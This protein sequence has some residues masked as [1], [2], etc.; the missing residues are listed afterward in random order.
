M[1][2]GVLLLALSSACNCS[3]EPLEQALGGPCYTDEA[4]QAIEVKID[5][6]DFKYL[7][8]GICSTGI[9]ARSGADLVC[10]DEIKPRKE[11][12]NS[13]DDDCNGYVDD[14]DFQPGTRLQMAR[15]D[16]ENFCVGDGVCE[17][18]TQICLNGR[19]NC[20]H[21]P[22]YGPE[23]C[24]GDDNDCDGKI[25]EDTAEEPLFAP[26]DRF[27][28]DGDPNTINVGECRAG[29]KQCVGGQVYIR[30]M[31]TPVTE[32]CGNDDDDDCDG[33]VDEAD[34]DPPL[35]DYVLVIDFSG[36]MEVFID[37]VADSLCLWSAQGSLQDSRFAVIAVGYVGFAA[38]RTDTALLTDF[39]D[40]AT[41][42][43]IIQ[44]NNTPEHFGNSEYQIDAIFNTWV[45][46][47]DLLLSW[48][49]ENDKRIFVFTDEAM[50][51]SIAN[52]EQGAIDM[53]VAQCSAND[54]EV[55][56][57]VNDF[58]PS[59]P[60]WVDLTQRCNGFL[61]YLTED[62]QEMIFKLNYWVGS[63]CGGA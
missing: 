59:Q 6:A 27:V 29:Y 3:L 58:N 57:F 26:Q 16:P 37:S 39:T 43:E 32:I 35:I 34:D 14:N 19:W 21:P 40:S 53:V 15:E 45:F 54:Y 9:L 23:V 22:Q 42:C 10:Q 8:E 38:D 60:G 33:W 20:L 52:N 36:S 25:D 5:S 1:K 12:C 41:A 62:A 2:S 18:S 4:G 51:Y 44:S 30:G 47:S 46:D 24:D 48:N 49:E 11:T 28:Y 50:Q 56:A 55:G 17:T 13:L 63:R 7:N 61:D 31:R